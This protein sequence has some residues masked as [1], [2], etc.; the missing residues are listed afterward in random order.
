MAAINNLCEPD[1]RMSKAVDCR[2]ELDLRIGSAFTRFQT[3]QLQRMY[4]IETV[5][6]YGSCQFPTLG[7]VVERWKA[8]KEFISEP[9]WKIELK[10]GVS[11]FSWKRQRL[12]DRELVLAILEFC[13]ASI[14]AKITKVTSRPKSR[15]R[16]IAMD[17][18]L[19]ER[20]A[21]QKLRMSAKTA[22]QVAEKLYNRGFLSYPRT[23]TNIFP[24]SINLRPLVENHVGNPEYAPFCNRILNEWNG[25]TP[26]NG[27]KSDQAHPPIHPKQAPDGSF[28]N[29]EKRLYNLIT[30]HFLACVSRD[31]K[32]HETVVECE[33]GGEEFKAEGLNITERNYLDIYPF[34]F[35]NSKQVG[36]YTL[37][38]TFTPEQISMLS[39]STQAP[40]LLTESDLIQLMDKNGIGTDATHAEHIE[41]IKERQYTAMKQGKFFIP[42]MLGLSLVEGYSN[43]SYLLLKNFSAPAMR[44]NLEK[45]LKK[46][47]DGVRTKEQVLADQIRVYKNA[48]IRADEE[49][50]V[51]KNS[52]RFYMTHGNGTPGYVPPDGNFPD[53]RPDNR[54]GNNA[55]NDNNND[56]S[57][58]DEPP[59][60]PPASGGLTTASTLTNLPDYGEVCS[61]FQPRSG[62]R[63]CSDCGADSVLKKF[64]PKR[65]FVFTCTACLNALGSTSSKIDNITTSTEL[66]KKCIKSGI[67]KVKLFFTPNSDFPMWLGSE[68]TACVTP[69]CDDDLAGKFKYIRNLKTVIQPKIVQAPNQTRFKNTG[70]TGTHIDESDQSNDQVQCNCGTPAV[71]LQVKKDGPNKGR[72]FHTCQSKACQFFEWV[73]N[74]K[75]Q[76]KK[77]TQINQAQ[78]RPTSTKTTNCNCNKPAKQLTVSKEGPNKGRQF[79]K[80]E[81][82]S[83]N[84]FEWADDDKSTN[85]ST[86]SKNT[87]KSV[88]SK[89][90][91]ECNRA[92]ALRTVTRD[93]SI[94]KGK[95]FYTCANPSNS[96]NF[97]QWFDEPP[98]QVKISKPR[99]APTCSNCKQV[100]HTKRGCPKLKS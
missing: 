73:E 40:S 18:I 3:L 39:G 70:R 16:P 62:L 76:R 42:T 33:L 51:L 53:F 22:M 32:G 37:N 90:N 80:C 86:S 2:Q 68:Y 97:F 50:M 87:L 78:K 7:F 19:M 36:N 4:N 26:R 35:W 81:S 82:S 46:I 44:S 13:E 9:F 54:P 56:S 1:E 28:T 59:P 47:C 94:N 64:G 55:G 65:L 25:P 74:A 99:K 57:S 34:D 17:T 79:Y 69:N 95:Q 63:T 52:L 38:Q 60:P 41:K 77:G 21:S 66:C 12:F 10:H 45:D 89:I 49:I 30:R 43:M 20:L 58:D 6:S 27:R 75:E 91:C 24:P 15:W 92:A 61:Q 8:N 84:F 14:P 98:Q 48:F 100:G 29:D 11:V 67:K 85:R 93:Q 23:E 71:K 72:Y 5:I 83:C 96:C 88:S 31:A